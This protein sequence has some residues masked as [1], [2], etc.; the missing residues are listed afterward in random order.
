MENGGFIGLFAG[1]ALFNYQI[2][3]LIEELFPNPN[4][5]VAGY[6]PGMQIIFVDNTGKLINNASFNWK[7]KMIDYYFD[8]K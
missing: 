8:L 2:N 7:I 3:I 6:Y 5:R 4:F 1:N